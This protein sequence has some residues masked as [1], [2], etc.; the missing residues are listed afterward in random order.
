M[1]F[2][3]LELVMLL[4]LPDRSVYYI[5]HLFFITLFLGLGVASLIQT[6]RADPGKVTLD[7]IEQIKLNL[8]F[9]NPQN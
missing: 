7:I 5:I 8:K 4:F 9:D 2:A 1:L 3:Y 6:F